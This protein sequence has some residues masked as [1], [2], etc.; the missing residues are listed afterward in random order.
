MAGSAN[1]EKKNKKK[2]TFSCVSSVVWVLATTVDKQFQYR[3]VGGLQGA[4]VCLVSTILSTMWW[5]GSFRTV[6]RGHLLVFFN[7][8]CSTMNILK[9]KQGELIPTGLKRWP[10]KLIKHF[11]DTTRVSPFPAGPAG[12]CPLHFLNLINLKFWVR[13]ANGYCIL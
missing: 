10:F 5:T 8:H 1:F 7:R 4:T 9:D 13:A 3:I 11:V 6:N 2:N 12:R